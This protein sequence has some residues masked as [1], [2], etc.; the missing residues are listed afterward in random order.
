[1]HDRTRSCVHTVCSFGTLLALVVVCLP[2]S[3]L[4]AHTRAQQEAAQSVTVPARVSQ[5]PVIHE[6]AKEVGVVKG[7]KF[8][9]FYASPVQPDGQQFIQVEDSMFRFPDG[10]LRRSGNMRLSEDARKDMVAAALRLSANWQLQETGT[11]FRVVPGYDYA[12]QRSGTFGGEY[13]RGESRTSQL[14]ARE[15]ATMASCVFAWSLLM[16]DP[17][18]SNVEE[19]G[20]YTVKI[21][22]WSAEF[23]LAPL[24]R[25]PRLHLTKY[26]FGRQG[27]KS[28]ST[29]SD[30]RPVEKYPRQVAYRELVEITASPGLVIANRTCASFI[31]KDE[32]S[33]DDF[34]SGISSVVET[35]ADPSTVQTPPAKPGFHAI[36]ADV[37]NASKTVR[38]SGSPIS[39][40][41]APSGT[42]SSQGLIALICVFALSMIVAVV[43]LLSR[44][45]A[46]KSV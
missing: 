5:V 21:P 40:T 43:V 37:W 18:I 24:P 6:W 36:P 33:A 31:V 12:V 30:F 19:S 14:F 9:A 16:S 41:P 13:T 10:L 34:A 22:E 7:V 32:I 28:R 20:V 8:T 25:D 3:L 39:A 1:M 17:L 23:T 46:K 44:W 38:A 29:F 15:H 35:N 26:E 11:D 4:A 2:M 42:A 27:R 45:K